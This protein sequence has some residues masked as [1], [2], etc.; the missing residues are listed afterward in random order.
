MLIMSTQKRL[1]LLSIVVIALLVMQAGASWL[2][3]QL[4][5]PDANAAPKQPP[6]PTATLKSPPCDDQECSN[7]LTP[8]SLQGGTPVRGKG[9]LPGLL[10]G[11]AGS[12]QVPPTPTKSPRLGTDRIALTPGVLAP[13]CFDGAQLVSI[14]PP[15]PVVTA[16][17]PSQVTVNLK[18]TGNCAWGTDWAFKWVEK[19]RI[20]ANPLAVSPSTTVPAGA[21]YGFV[22]TFVAPAAG[23]FVTHWTLRAPDRWVGPTVE[24]VVRARASLPANAGP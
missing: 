15:Q 4:V 12:V 20:G 5:V 16:R 9:T 21:T 11:N 13:P 7:L 24:I 14:Q 3:L 1:A 22:L 6:A 10:P 23:T 17:F 2:G 19:D 18:N 8:Q